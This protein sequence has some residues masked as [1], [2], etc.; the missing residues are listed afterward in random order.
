MLN[1][2][3]IKSLKNRPLGLTIHIMFLSLMKVT[4]MLLPCHLSLIFG[5]CII[6]LFIYNVYI[7]AYMI[8]VSRWQGTNSV[9]LHDSG[10]SIR[11]II[12]S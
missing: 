3:K 11:L 2:K 5:I 4:P 8:T 7:Y 10:Y 6:F 12:I 9:L 1:K